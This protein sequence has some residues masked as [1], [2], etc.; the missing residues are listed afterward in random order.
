M[1]LGLTAKGISKKLEGQ[2]IAQAEAR[3]SVAS[4][5]SK[6][7]LV[8][9]ELDTIDRRITALHHEHV[10]QTMKDLGPE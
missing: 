3:R 1:P 2:R 4:L 5:R 8:E 6:L 10:L 7:Y 9:I